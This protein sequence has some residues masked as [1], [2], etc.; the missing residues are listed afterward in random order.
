MGREL[1][2]VPLDFDWPLNKV[3]KG[4]VNPLHCAEQCNTCGGDGY[5]PEARAMKDRWYGHAPFKPEDRGSTPF[6]PTDAPIRAFA[7][8]NVSNAPDYY[9]RG[10]AAIER[11]AQRLCKLFN[12]QWSHHLNADDVAALIAG[13]RLWDFT[14]DFVPGKGWQDKS[15]P[16]VP[17]PTQVNAWSIGGMGH[18]SIN[19]W[20]VVRAECK[21]LGL[22]ETCAVCGG[23]GERW[24][25]L[26]AKKAYEEW[27][28]EEPPTGD[29]YQIWETVSEGSPI[30][31]P[32]SAPE[33]LARH[34]ATTKWGADEGTPYETWLAFICGPG[35]VPSMI[36]DSSGLRTGV[37]AVVDQ[38]S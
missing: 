3:W 37:E 1:K 10:E 8:R 15:V 17:T 14:R 22:S 9:G 18:D 12:S 5:S 20:I 7:E 38:V 35:W 33:D 4:F 26:E 24:P 27:E 30:S 23:E 16:T 29:G 36:G 11:E 25:S 31:P 28:Q 21:R 2:R 13:D 34:M 19:Q 32:F 6:L